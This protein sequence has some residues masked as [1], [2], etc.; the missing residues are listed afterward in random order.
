L[1]PSFLESL[2]AMPRSASSQG[3]HFLC[4]MGYNWSLATSKMFGLFMVILLA[5]SLFYFARKKP[6]T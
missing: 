5:A 6:D 4:R 2:E 3:Y 1:W